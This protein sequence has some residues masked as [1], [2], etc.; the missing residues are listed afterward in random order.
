MQPLICL[1]QAALAEAAAERTERARLA[2]ELTES[3]GRRRAEGRALRAQLAAE[4]AEARAEAAAAAGQERAR[5]K[6]LV[7]SL[8]AQRAAAQVVMRVV[9][10]LANALAS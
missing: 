9:Q 7:A 3:E 4:V 1:R 8:Q 10:P 5:G 6:A 2:T